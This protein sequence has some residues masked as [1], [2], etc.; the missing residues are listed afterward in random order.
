MLYNHI[1]CTETINLDEINKNID[2]YLKIINYHKIKLE[3]FE[4][5]YTPK[6]SIK[7][8]KLIDY[9]SNPIY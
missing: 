5:F 8:N 9:I 4:R 7:R 1:I 2:S 3:K 6:M